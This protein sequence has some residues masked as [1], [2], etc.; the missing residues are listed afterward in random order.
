MNHDVTRDMIADLWPLYRAGECSPTTQ[1]MIEAFL[2]A[3]PAFR[4]DLERSA[5]MTAMPPVHLSPDS[6]RILLAD[7]RA[8]ANMKYITIMVAVGAFCLFAVTLMLTVLKFMDA[9]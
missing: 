6:E 1:S 2:A 5:Q 4:S 9:I 8:K 7:A 3:D